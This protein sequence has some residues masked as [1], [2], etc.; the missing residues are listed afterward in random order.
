MAKYFLSGADSKTEYRTNFVQDGFI[1]W[2]TKMKTCIAENEK[3]T[4]T[5]HDLPM[6]QPVDQQFKI[7]RIAAIKALKEFR[8]NHTLGQFSLKSLIEDGRD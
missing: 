4:T 8:T 2:E 1:P 7:N 5:K 6:M 3:T